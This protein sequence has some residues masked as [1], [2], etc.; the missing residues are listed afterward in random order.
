MRYAMISLIL[1]FSLVGCDSG[2]GNG[3]PGGP[4]TGGPG[5]TPVGLVEIEPGAIWGPVQA[6]MAEVPLVFELGALGARF[7]SPVHGVAGILT[8][9]GD[10]ATVVSVEWTAAG[11][12]VAG[13]L[14]KAVASALGD[15]IEDLYMDAWWYP[16]DGLL[17]EFE[18]D[19]VARVHVFTAAQ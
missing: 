17:I 9:T 7:E 10:D 15:P 6:S 4:D 16:A 1:A 11:G 14:R 8:G 18:D 5:D 2:D 3:A 12:I 19:V 13:D